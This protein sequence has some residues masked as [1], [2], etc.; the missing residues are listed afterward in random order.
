MRVCVS[1]DKQS[2]V[3]DHDLREAP[4]A[5]RAMRRSEIPRSI[6]SDT[7]D[8]A[9]LR[10]SEDDHG[11]DDDDDD[12]DDDDVVVVVAMSCAWRRWSP[13]R[14][15]SGEERMSTAASKRSATH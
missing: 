6:A 4:L 1:A 5:S 12:D 7:A 3:D 14:W 2:S 10:E 15:A 9:M 13:P 8:T 11:N